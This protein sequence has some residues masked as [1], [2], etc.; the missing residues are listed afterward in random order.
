MLSI[1]ETKTMTLTLRWEGTNR[2][3]QSYLFVGDN[4]FYVVRIYCYD[5]DDIWD[6]DFLLPELKDKKVKGYESA[7]L[8]AESYIRVW[9]F[10]NLGIA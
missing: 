1:K 8:L 7:K 6:I 10:E 4:D 9:Y 2:N 3:P 5:V